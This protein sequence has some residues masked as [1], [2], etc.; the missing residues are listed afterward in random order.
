MF[1]AYLLEGYRILMR[2]GLALIKSYK[3]LIKGNK[4]TNAND[5]WSSI[6]RNARNDEASL[7][8]PSCLNYNNQS[9]YNNTTTTTIE[10]PLYKCCEVH[11]TAY[12]NDRSLVGK[13]YRPMNI[14]HQKLT[15]INSRYRDNATVVSFH[16]FG[17]I[18]HTNTNDDVTMKEEVKT[19]TIV[20][21]N[22]SINGSIIKLASSSSILSKSNADTLIRFLPPPT[23]ID[24]LALVYSSKSD[25]WD[26]SYLYN[27]LRDINGPFVIILGTKT[28][29]NA[30]IGVYVTSSI[31]PPDN[32][33]RGTGESFV[34]RLDDDHEMKYPWIG[35]DKANNTMI[36]SLAPSVINQFAMF[37]ND[38]MSF[39]CGDKYATNAIY[40]PSNLCNC[41]SGFSDTYNNPPLISINECLSSS[42]STSST[43]FDINDIEIYSL[44]STYNKAIK[45]GKFEKRTSILVD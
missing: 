10:T 11:T 23:A 32:K 6:Q 7:V 39:G 42:S 14:S 25:G 36:S 22:S 19:S 20:H 30:I 29:S 45:H 9:C 37:S 34:F 12:E 18:D 31:S 2:Y 27:K 17:E 15:E 21:S 26:L 33:P 1:D 35:I 13:A 40:I 5:F 28:T 3:R 44:Q 16:C 4:Y 38:Y 24:G 43:S 8:Y 41:S